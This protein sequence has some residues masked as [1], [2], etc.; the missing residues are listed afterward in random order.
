[1]TADRK[2]AWMIPTEVPS[3]LASKVVVVFETPEGVKI[4]RITDPTEKPLT[5]QSAEPWNRP[6]EIVKSV[7]TPT[8]THS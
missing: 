7:N 3:G 1:M 2:D 4:N 5:D 6:L 8:A